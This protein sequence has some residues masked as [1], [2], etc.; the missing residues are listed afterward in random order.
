LES[1]LKEY[2]GKTKFTSKVKDWELYYSIE[3]ETKEQ[4][5][6]I[7][8]HLKRMKSKMYYRNLKKYPENAVKLLERYK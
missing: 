8:R 7:E 2:Y 3:C 5:M 6:K 1:H 4:A